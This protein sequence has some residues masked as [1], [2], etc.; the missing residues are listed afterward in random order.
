MNGNGTYVRRVRVSGSVRDAPSLRLDIQ[1][2]LAA[3]LGRRTGLP[4]SA[5]VCIRTFPAPR[6]E[7]FVPWQP[8]GTAR[9]AWEQGVG[10]TLA[11]LVWHAARPIHGAPPAHAPAVLFWDQSELLAC[12]ASDWLTGTL[13]T[14]WWWQGLLGNMPDLAGV[15]ATWRGQ[16]A[17]IPAALAHLAQ[18]DEAGA[19]VTALLPDQAELLRQCLCETFALPLA[20]PAQ[21]LP[22]ASGGMRTLSADEN[23]TGGPGTTTA[24]SHRLVPE[25]LGARLTAQQR[26]F[27]VTSLLL[28]RAPALA[29]QVAFED[30]VSASVEVG[31]AEAMGSPARAVPLSNRT[32]SAVS[33]PGPTLRDGTVAPAG[34]AAPFAEVRPGTVLD[35][36]Q[37][38]GR[39]AST[40]GPEMSDAPYRAQTGAS[41]PSFPERDSVWQQRGPL[42]TAYGGLFFLVNVGLFLELYG[43]FTQP[44]AP[45]LDLPI[46]DFIALLGQHLVGNGLQHDPVWSLLAALAGRPVQQPPG[47]GFEP[48]L[49]WRLPVSWLAPFG[50]GPLH[51]WQ[52]DGRLRVQHPA[53]FAA[54]DIALERDPAHELAGLVEAYAAVGPCAL[55]REPCPAEGCTT[56]GLAR[57]LAWL[58]PY[59]RARLRLA[60]G[61]ARDEEPG[62]L[63]CAIPARVYSAPARIDVVMVLRDLPIEVRLAGLD[64]DPGW[65]P[66][67]GCNLLFHF[68]AE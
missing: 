35:T 38:T 43:D 1:R 39:S 61:S 18:R 8:D 31:S 56:R 51:W 37:R 28:Q 53:G 5:T 4:P 29:R 27:L 23:Q 11:D 45:G 10:A 65:L 36:A 62:P 20:R 21:H 68:E 52:G 41:V 55:L 26:A 58:V 24:A 13:A 33:F 7:A 9:R 22:V 40:D 34:P 66:G 15:V 54:L 46:W 6:R 16:P 60:L 30:L 2:A 42:E 50:C 44:T 14:R 19:F 12:L 63:L 67:A 64:R 47:E 59:V 32:P 49:E 48:D 57:W 3:A 17:S 25:A